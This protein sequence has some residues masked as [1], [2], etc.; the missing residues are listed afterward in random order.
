MNT[1]WR[2]AFSLVLVLVAV[3]C[4]ADDK[5]RQG[6]HRSKGPHGKSKTVTKRPAQPSRDKKHGAAPPA[7]PAGGIDAATRARIDA[8]IR[9][10]D[11]NPYGDPKD[12]MYAGGTPLFDE[13]TGRRK[14]R[15]EYILQKH[16]EL[17]SQ[18]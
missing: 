7:A 9:A 4:G 1:I 10:N 17:R 8:W 15:Y 16:P 3:R 11:R 2:M 6:T 13:R 12:T 18:K 5:S 14:D